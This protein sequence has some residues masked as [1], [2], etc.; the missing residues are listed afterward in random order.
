MAAFSY[1]NI[2]NDSNS[3]TL[4]ELNCEYHLSVS[5]EDDIDL[6]S[7]SC[8]ANKLAEKLKK[9]IEICY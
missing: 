8:S 1:N 9:L 4:F 2:K 6:R 5:F 7:K 3:H